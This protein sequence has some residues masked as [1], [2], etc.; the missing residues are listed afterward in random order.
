[1][2]SSVKSGTFRSKSFYCLFERFLSYLMC[3]PSVKSL[4]SSFLS[5]KKCNGDNV[6][7]NPCKQLWGQNTLVGVWLIELTEPSNPLHYKPF[8]KHCI[9]HTILHVFLLL[10]LCETKSFV[11][12]TE[13][14]FFWFGLVW[15]S[16]LQY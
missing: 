7:P 9:L 1:M 5:R 11:L 3:V 4:N 16:V 13:Q 6:T 2:M 12:K 10:Y 15:H 14:Y 8:F